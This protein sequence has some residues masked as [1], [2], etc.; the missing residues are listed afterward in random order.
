MERTKTFIKIW[1]WPNR[2]TTLPSDAANSA[3]TINTTAWVCCYPPASNTFI[4]IT[5]T[6]IGDSYCIFSKHVVRFQYLLWSQ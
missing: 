2:D 1:F 4:L 3:K 6:H 5:V